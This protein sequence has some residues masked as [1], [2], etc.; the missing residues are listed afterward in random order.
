[1]SNWIVEIQKGCW[2]SDVEG[3][4]G[5]TLII[6]SAR[7][8]ESKQE[9]I[10][11]LFEAE[12]YRPFPNALVKPCCN[13]SYD[14]IHDKYDTDCGESF[15]FEAE[16]PKKN[17]Y[18]GYKWMAFTGIPVRG[19]E[20]YPRKQRVRMLMSPEQIDARRNNIDAAK[21]WSDI[22][23]ATGNE[24]LAYAY[25]SSGGYIASLPSEKDM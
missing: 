12:S 18:W 1:M 14:E 8:Y 23:P 3:D 15:A 16:G 17:K 22:Q 24:P 6:G 19:T 9:A 13:W 20:G 2:L 4:P 10:D 5:R 25:C 21:E 7:R 11:A